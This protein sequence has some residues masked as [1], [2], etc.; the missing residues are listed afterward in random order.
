[1]A[2]H[3]R[4]IRQWALVPTLRDRSSSQVLLDSTTREPQRKE[5]VATQERRPFSE[6]TLAD[7]E[8]YHPLALAREAAKRRQARWCLTQKRAFR[9]LAEKRAMHMGTDLQRWVETNEW[10]R[11]DVQQPRCAS[12]S[13]HSKLAGNVYVE[14]TVPGETVPALLDSGSGRSLLDARVFTP[15]KLEGFRQCTQADNEPFSDAPGNCILVMT[16]LNSRPADG[17]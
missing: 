2:I 10:V 9:A 11:Y 16:D 4:A 13:K 6:Y 14:A 3:S 12:L 7:S 8:S 15:D 17:K 1:M 5:D